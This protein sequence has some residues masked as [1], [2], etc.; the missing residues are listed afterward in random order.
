MVHKYKYKIQLQISIIF[1]C[2]MLIWG[3]VG[4]LFN[5]WFLYAFLISLWLIP[6]I[7]TLS[8]SVIITDEYIE[9]IYLWKLFTRKVFWENIQEFSRIPRSTSSTNV[10]KHDSIHLWSNW[11]SNIL[12]SSYLKLII[13]NDDAFYIET[14]KIKKGYE[15]YN[16]LIKNI[17]E[18]KS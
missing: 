3:Y 11:F 7:Y 17:H 10:F 1:T 16:L 13:T 18:I 4:S 2:I 6:I 8:K 5:Y 14:G 12:N 9:K 15:I